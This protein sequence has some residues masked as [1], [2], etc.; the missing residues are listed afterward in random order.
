[1]HKS[2]VRLLASKEIEL[3]TAN[4][5]YPKA[6]KEARILIIQLNEAH[7]STTTKIE[8]ITLDFIKQIVHLLCF[9]SFFLYSTQ[10]EISIVFCAMFTP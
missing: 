7:K 10:Y 5:W 6:I 8:D 2:D 1:M 9:S 4:W 3:C